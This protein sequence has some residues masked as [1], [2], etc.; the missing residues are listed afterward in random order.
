MRLSLSSTKSYVSD[1]KRYNIGKQMF[2]LG[3]DFYFFRGSFVGWPSTRT[4]SIAFGGVSRLYCTCPYQTTNQE[5]EENT[6]KTSDVRQKEDGKWKMRKCS[7]IRPP[8]R[9][10]GLREILVLSRLQRSP[11]PAAENDSRKYI[12]DSGFSY[13]TYYI[14]S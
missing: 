8:R 5:A 4:T 10:R 13:I 14:S 6:E 9:I 2:V 3:V 11:V 7:L 12:P 1:R